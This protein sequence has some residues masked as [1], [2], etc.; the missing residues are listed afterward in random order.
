MATRQEI[1]IE[2]LRVNTDNYRFEP[3]KS[4]LDAIFTLLDEQGEKLFRLAES[5]IVDGL[6]PADVV[7]VTP[8]SNEKEIHIVLEGNRRISALKILNVPSILDSYHDDS[9]KKKYRTLSKKVTNRTIFDVPCLVFEDPSEADHWI[10]LKH[11]GE[12]KGVGTVSWNAQQTRRFEQIHSGKSTIAMQAI[13]LLRSSDEVDDQLKTKLKK[14]KITNLDRLLTDKSVRD[15][16]GIELDNGVLK[17]KLARSEVVR[18]LSAIVIDL[19]DNGLTVKQIYTSEDRA[20]YLNSLDANMAP[21]PSV[22]ANEAWTLGQNPTSRRKSRVGTGSSSGRDP[23]TRKHLIPAGVNMPISNIKVASIYNEMKKLDVANYRNMIGITLR[24]FVELSV[25]SY[26][27]YHQIGGFKGSA[28]SSGMNFQ[29]KVLTVANHMES[30]GCDRTIT[31]G[32]KTSVKTSSHLLSPDTLHSYLHSSIHTPD[33]LSL[34]ITW[35]NLQS[36]LSRLWSTVL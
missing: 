10:K 20:E 11:S 28:A 14:V 24:V 12:N 22:T 9:I 29:Q 17:G 19:V 31:Q 26:L 32:I 2:N 21:N 27:D 6:N 34:K 4:Q 23:Q 3:Q 35:D 1:R 8:D 7:L 25:D 5:I 33:P 18:G 15:Y 13:E 30:T 16:L 36:F